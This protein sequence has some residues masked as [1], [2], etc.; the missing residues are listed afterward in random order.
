MWNFGQDGPRDADFET[1]N[2]AASGQGVKVLHVVMLGESQAFPVVGSVQLSGLEFVITC[3]GHEAAFT[4]RILA[5]TLGW[6]I[7][8][9]VAL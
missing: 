4:T 7:M 2:T 6:P 3:A 5:Q 9:T 8:H 1:S